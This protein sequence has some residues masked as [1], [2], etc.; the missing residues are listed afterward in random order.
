MAI[1]YSLKRTTS[2]SVAISYVKTV[3]LRA[4]VCKQK[5]VLPSEP[6]GES[7]FSPVSV[8]VV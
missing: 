4:I 1:G 7:A 8:Y 2:G 3:F 5:K 6:S